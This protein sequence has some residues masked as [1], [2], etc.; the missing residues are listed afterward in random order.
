M[1]EGFIE[2]VGPDGNKRVVPAHYLENKAF[3]FRLPPSAVAKQEQAPEP[4]HVE[5]VQEQ[6]AADT[7]EPKKEGRK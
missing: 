2:A 1:S 6:A 7:P 5:L 4:A 3:G